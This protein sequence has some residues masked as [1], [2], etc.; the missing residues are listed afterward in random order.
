MYRR[1]SGD[2]KKMKETSD[3]LKKAN[4]NEKELIVQSLDE[5]RRFLTK[6]IIDS[7]KTF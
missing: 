2:P 7:D 1:W 6:R 3:K 4:I 5:R